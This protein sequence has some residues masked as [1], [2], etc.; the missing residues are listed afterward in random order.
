MTFSKNF[1]LFTQDRNFTKSYWFFSI[2]V[3]LENIYLEEKNPKWF[4]HFFVFETN[5]FALKN[6]LSIMPVFCTYTNNNQIH[7]IHSFQIRSLLIGG[8]ITFP[9]CILVCDWLESCLQIEKLYVRLSR[10]YIC[11]NRLYFNSKYKFT[12]II[13]FVT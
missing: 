13:W 11:G 12:Q 10:I 7:V 6:L 2:L 8:F 3:I 9:L 5:P 1:G 4:L